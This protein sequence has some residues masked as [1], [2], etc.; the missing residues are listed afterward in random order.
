GVDVAGPIRGPEVTHAVSLV[1]AVP[2]VRARLVRMQQAIIA[3]CSVDD[4]GIVVEGRDI[5]T[6]VAPD[7]SVKLFLTASIDAR[8]DRRNLE[9]N[10][11]APAVVSVEATRAD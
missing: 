1:S 5:G 11:A 6:V 2:A 7:A 9:I 8:A 4:G 3:R 10:A